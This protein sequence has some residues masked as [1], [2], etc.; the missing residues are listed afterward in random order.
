MPRRGGALTRRGGEEGQGSWGSPC[1]HASGW[2]ARSE[3]RGAF[4]CLGEEGKINKPGRLYK[5]RQEETGMLRS[6][7]ENVR[8][9]PS[10]S[11]HTRGLR[12]NTCVCVL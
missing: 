6:Q 3:L 1:V 10:F 4:P 8:L 7:K 12:V 9:S 2:Q 5:E 11:S